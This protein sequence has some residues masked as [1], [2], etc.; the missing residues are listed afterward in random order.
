M[1]SSSIY[2]GEYSYE[3]TPNLIRGII[4]GIDTSTGLCTYKVID[5]NGNTYNNVL[6]IQDQGNNAGFHHTPYQINQSVILLTV[7]RN[8]PP[9]IL[10]SV[11]K[12]PKIPIPQQSDETAIAVGNDNDTII[13]TDHMIAN[14]GNF[15]NLSQQNGLTISAQDVLRL[16][17]KNSSCTLRISAEGSDNDDNPLNGQEFITALFAYLDVLEA[18]VLNNSAAIAAIGPAAE[19]S[20]LARAAVLTNAGD[21]NGAA[22]ETQRAGEIAF[23]SNAASAALTSTSAGTKT[24]CEA[25]KNTKIILPQD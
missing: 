10:G 25:S 18:K 24:S 16:Q 17:L 22:Q 19:S 20:A 23:T 9:Y 8:D 11:Y 1:R 7:S 6:V 15:V 2:R 12:P 4:K 13:Q 3:S 21:A 14:G 5:F